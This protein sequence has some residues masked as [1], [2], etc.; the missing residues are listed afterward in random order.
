MW[1]GAKIEGKRDRHREIRRICLFP[2]FQLQSPLF[3]KNKKI[4][5][6]THLFTN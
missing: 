2:A 5:H 6:K 4:I 1:W 3:L